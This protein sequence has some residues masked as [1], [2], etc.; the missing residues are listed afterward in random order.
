MKIRFYKKRYK[1]ETKRSF[2]LKTWCDD[3]K[4]GIQI[5]L[6]LQIRTFWTDWEITRQKALRPGRFITDN[7]K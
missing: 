5:V 2:R 7:D 3:V 1:I 6:K 4:I